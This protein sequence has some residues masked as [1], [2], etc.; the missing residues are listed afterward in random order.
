MKEHLWAIFRKGSKSN[1]VTYKQKLLTRR[2]DGGNK[3]RRLLQKWSNQVSVHLF[4]F[5]SMTLP[6]FWK[7]RRTKDKEINKKWLANSLIPVV[8]N[9]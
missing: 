6:E 3:M 1:V 7:E 5:S 4:N 9:Y 2:R 8:I